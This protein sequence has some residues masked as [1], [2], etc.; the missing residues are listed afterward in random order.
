MYNIIPYVK[1]PKITT[2][3]LQLSGSFLQ[4]AAAAKPLVRH[5]K[6]EKMGFVDVQNA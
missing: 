2:Q 1:C 5:E 3:Q 4:D 6:G